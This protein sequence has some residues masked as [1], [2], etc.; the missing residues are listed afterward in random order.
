[1]SLRVAVTEVGAGSVPLL[2]H[3]K[4]SGLVFQPPPSTV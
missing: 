3:A 2:W 1:M 4:A